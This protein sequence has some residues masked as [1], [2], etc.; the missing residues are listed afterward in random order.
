MQERS[1]PCREP[2][3][4]SWQ[5]PQNGRGPDR[6]E[7]PQIAVTLLGHAAELLLTA[8]RVL[9]R[10]QPDPCCELAPRFESRRIDDSGG[11]GRCGDRS[12]AWN[13]RQAAADRVGF[14][15]PHEHPFD[16]LDA[17][18]QGA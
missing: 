15:L 4:L 7:A 2:V 5:S 12:D 16:L 8:T 11:D 10:Y 9:A 18:F 17:S 6:E 13:A 14:M 3:R 1:K